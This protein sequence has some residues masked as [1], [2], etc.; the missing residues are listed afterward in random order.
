MPL[1]RMTGPT[2]SRSAI[3]TNIPWLY[4]AIKDHN[5]APRSNCA[6]HTRSRTATLTG[7][8]PLRPDYRMAD[9]SGFA[10]SAAPS[11]PSK[12]T[13]RSSPLPRSARLGSTI[14][15]RRPT[16]PRMATAPNPHMDLLP[17]VAPPA[18]QGA[19][20]DGK[21]GTIAEQQ[22]Y[23]TPLG[24][25]HS[26]WDRAQRADPLCDAARRYIQLGHPNPLPRSFC[27]HL[28]SHMRPETTDI[29]DLAAKGRLL[30]GDHDS[31]LLVRKP[32]TNALTPATHSGR[33]S[34]V[35]FDDPIRIYVPHL[36]R[37][38]ITH[39][40]TKCWNASTGGSVWKSAQ[41]GG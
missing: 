16:P 8:T 34:R 17:P 27:D 24:Y 15:L 21:T 35:P 13:L 28:P 1:N 40:Y 18:Q 32:I 38:W 29:A 25:S 20:L 33:R 41:N 26:D 12:A 37:P 4:Y 7:N 31:T 6:R 14:L 30:Q 2:A 39:A 36:V 22:L 5:E 9:R 11:P 19:T 10:T 23:N 3:A